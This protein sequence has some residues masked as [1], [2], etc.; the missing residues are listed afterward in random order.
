MVKR[1]IDSDIFSKRWF[2]VLSAEEKVLWL[3]ITNQ[4]TYDGF[5]EHDK[6]VVKFYCGYD[7]DIPDIIK[8]KLG[9]HKIDDEQWFLKNWVSFQ[10]G[11]LRTNLRPHKRIIE[12]IKSKGLDDLFP[13]LEEEMSIEYINEVQHG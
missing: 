13:E 5:W 3:L 8:A 7:G 2:R 1:F 10:Y 9:M 4:C 11:K 6:E 12:R